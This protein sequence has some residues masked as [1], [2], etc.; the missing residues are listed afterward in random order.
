MA[1]RDQQNFKQYIEMLK[2]A[3]GGVEPLLKVARGATSRGTGFES[4]RPDTARAGLEAIEKNRELPPPQYFGL[5]ALIAEEIRPAFEILNGSFAA[6]HPLW[7][8]LT[9]DPVLKSRI[10]TAI[11]SV[12]RIELPGNNRYPYGGTGFVV[13]KNLIMTNR[14][15]AEIFTVGL[16]NR[17]LKFITGAKAG[18]D[19]LR[20]KGGRNGQ[21]LAVKNILM[22]H[23]YWDLSILE[24]EGLPAE[25]PQV[26][27]S[28]TDARQ[29][30]V[31]HEVF[32]IGYPAYDPRNPADAQQKLFEGIYGIK[33]LQPGALHGA[34]ETASFGKLVHATTHDCSTLGGNSGSG[35]FDLSSGEV[36]ALHFGGQ[37]HQANFGVPTFEMARDSRI[38]DLGVSF[39]GN[40]PGDPNGWS[41]WWQ[42]A[43]EESNE[44]APIDDAQAPPINASAAS[45]NADLRSNIDG[46]VSIEVPLRITVSLGVPMLGGIAVRPSRE[47]VV[48]SGLEA[49]RMPFHDTDYASRKGYDA[50]F[51]N[52]PKAMPPIE[53]PMPAATD[54]SVLAR[55]SGGGT[56]LHYQNFSI[57]MHAKRRL[58]LFTASNVTGEAKLRK[59]ELGRDYTRKA[60]GGLGK[61]DQER[62]FPD[63][64][65]DDEF[66]LPDVFYNKDRT[67]FDKGHIV[68]RDDVAWGETYEALRRANGDSYHFTNCSPQVAS[69]NRSN[70]GDDNWGNLENHVLSEAASERLCVFAGP[71]LDPSDQV[72]VGV[73]DAGSVVRSRIPT[74][75]WKLIVSRVEG[76]IAVY[77]FVLAQDLKDVEWEFAVPD[78]FVLAHY[79]VTDLQDI[80][81]VKFDR[82]IVDADQYE[83]SRG[84]EVARRA[85]VRLKRKT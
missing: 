71:V 19:F 61:N 75:F 67:A 82:S 15:V 40:A 11:P 43:D 7:T 34:G 42:R 41:E 32:V 63:S 18:I 44:Q 5:E 39:S 79:P 66:Q 64:R 12:G 84:A 8:K 56:V 4:V 38:V 65:L 17:R 35:V 3:H 50:L 80:A 31:G 73:G 59:P 78:E 47:A 83:T 9:S 57:C 36:L 33:R 49:L 74:R 24:V 1:G 46:T 28:L 70:L 23:P 53:V 37:Y 76:G 51:L 10:E 20:E 30:P 13:G 72:F 14:H 54:T 77:A 26:K 16:G 55:L 48:T 85:G 29:L 2:R 81:G 52:S 68:R 25:H 21:T 45:H 6:P 62:W 69:F 27:L 22:I 60:L 58:A